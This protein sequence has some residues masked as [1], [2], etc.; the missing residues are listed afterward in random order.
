MAAHIR[1]S[2]HLD[3]AKGRAKGD[4]RR[5]GGWWRRERKREGG[6]DGR[7]E[8][9]AEMKRAAE[10]GGGWNYHNIG[11]CLFRWMR[12]SSY[13]STWESFTRGRNVSRVETFL[14]RMLASGEIVTPDFP[15]PRAS[16]GLNLFASSK[17]RVF[18]FNLSLVILASFFLLL[19]LLFTRTRLQ[20]LFLLWKLFGMCLISRF[21]DCLRF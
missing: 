6:R 1:D 2:V 18:F 19:L 21:N 3:V 15:S 9:G 17:E 13:A 7:G 14:A 11:H 20:G 5:E 8:V 12:R 4:W 16:R 10:G